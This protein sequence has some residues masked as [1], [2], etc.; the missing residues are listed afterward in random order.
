MA[1]TRTAQRAFEQTTQNVF[2]SVA[3]KI[4]PAGRRALAYWPPERK[5]TGDEK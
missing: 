1:K 4:S 2:A 5:S 3:A